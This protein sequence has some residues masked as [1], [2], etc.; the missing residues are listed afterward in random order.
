MVS[1]IINLFLSS[2]FLSVSGY[3]LLKIGFIK[4]N[5]E[6]AEAG[7]YG[8]I[9]LG[10]LSL[11]INFF[12]PLNKIINTTIL[13]LLLISF[14]FQNRN[15]LSK[16]KEILIVS[17]KITFIASIF[18]S[19]SK[20]FDPDAFLYHLPYTNLINDFK[21]LPGSSLIHYRFGH[22]SIIQYINALFNNHIFGVSGVTIPTSM[23]FSF[24]FLFVANEINKILKNNNFF[25]LYNFFIISSFIFLCL[26]MNRYSDYGNDHIG[27]IFF[28]YFISIFIKNFNTKDLEI[29]KYLSLLATFIFTIKIF[30]F[31]PL[32]LCTYLW[33]L[34]INIK[35]INVANSICLFLFSFWLIKNILISGCAVYPV[36]FTCIDKLPWYNTENNSFINAEQISLSS[37]AWSKNWNT[38]YNKQRL[39][40][41]DLDKL[42]SQT[43]YI[44]NFFWLNEWLNVHG[45]FILK[46]I[47]PFIIFI[48]ILYFLN[49][50]KIKKTKIETDNK[51]YL[52]L[53][54]IN[55][56]V[57]TLW[58]LKFPI[59]RYGLAYIFIQI[60]LISYIFFKNKY[61][62]NLKIVLLLSLFI[63]TSKNI[64][65]IINNFDYNIYP[66]TSKQV[67][68]FDVEKDNFKIYYTESLCG[69]NKSPCT[70][71]KP[72]IDNIDVKEYFIYKFISLK[73]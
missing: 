29:K 34:K 52:I 71:Y 28:I 12:L 3:Q 11:I 48:V 26:R 18:I 60:F 70:N 54:T 9:L 24:F 61:F 40:D 45:K 62:H 14:F 47:F 53:F 23:V 49:R 55:L 13:L 42:N 41:K 50:K 25:T 33:I 30:Y 6:T 19:F 38:H 16:I 7:L 59:M 37:E 69:Y 8:F 17:I 27:T 20:N 56:I 4:K 22:V 31:V 72:N 15:D 51:L 35:I 10:S 58:F 68:Y 32:I 65:K 36:S 46:K 63:L 21:I 57:L 73:N 66:E 67:R 64:L 43:E 39:V 44:T 2:I 5:I 1:L